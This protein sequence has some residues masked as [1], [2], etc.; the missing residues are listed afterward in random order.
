MAGACHKAPPAVDLD[1]ATDDQKALYALGRMLGGNVTR[2]H[3][4]DEQMAVATAGFVEAAQDKPARVDMQKAGPLLAAFERAQLARLAAPEREA[5][6]AFAD[7]E[8]K[9]KGAERLPSGVILRSVQDGKGANPTPD[10]VVV[11]NYS[12]QLRDGSEFDSS[13]KRGQPVNFGVNKVIACWTEGLQHMKPGGKA[14]LTCPADVAYGDGGAPPRIPPGATLA[15][16]VELLSIAPKAPP[17][18]AP[19]TPGHK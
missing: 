12:G 4:T 3:L 6:K 13:Y 5:G 10:D 8:A 15:F 11:V 9:E 14:H 16:E 17:A 2:L 7:Q 18:Q 1:K 19:A